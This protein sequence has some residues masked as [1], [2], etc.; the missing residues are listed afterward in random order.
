MRDVREFM[1]AELNRRGGVV[2]PDDVFERIR[3][4]TIKIANVDRS[5]IQLDTKF[6]D[7]LGLD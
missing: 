1:V 5:M 6:V 7:D 3:T 4:I 2:D